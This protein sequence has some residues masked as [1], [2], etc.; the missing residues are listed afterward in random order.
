MSYLWS[1]S[2]SVAIVLSLQK[3]NESFQI[4]NLRL[5]LF[6]ELLLCFER[7]DEL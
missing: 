6:N 1:I 7:V 3:G 4:N 2:S 5:K